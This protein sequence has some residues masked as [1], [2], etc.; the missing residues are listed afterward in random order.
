MGFSLKKREK[1]NFS[2]LCRR[3]CFIQRSSGRTDEFARLSCLSQWLCVWW[4][5]HLQVCD[6]LMYW[7]FFLSFSSITHNPLTLHPPSYNPPLC[8]VVVQFLWWQQRQ[9]VVSGPWWFTVRQYLMGIIESSPLTQLQN[10]IEPIWV[11]CWHSC[12][13]YG[14]VNNLLHDT[15]LLFSVKEKGQREKKMDHITISMPKAKD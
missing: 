6:C 5:D 9:T 10:Q 11:F 4:S 8:H 2:L 15:K 12:L 14:R 1:N 7:V 13:G 3:P